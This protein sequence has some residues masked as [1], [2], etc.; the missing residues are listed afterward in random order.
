MQSAHKSK[1]RSRPARVYSDQFFDVRIAP[2]R[3]EQGELFVIASRRS[4]TAVVR[5]TFK[6]RVRAVFREKKVSCLGYDWYFY[7][8]SSIKQCLFLHI[9][10]VV[11][12]ICRE[13]LPTFLS[14]V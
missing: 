11:D 7:A 12:T 3:G 8:K 14:P 9:S 4:G 2:A 6:R 10:G 1:P 5:N 13:V